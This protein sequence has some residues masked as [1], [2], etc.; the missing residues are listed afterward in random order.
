MVIQGTAEDGSGLEGTVNIFT[1]LEE[2]ELGVGLL[3]GQRGSRA[4]AGGVGDVA[5]GVH[6]AAPAGQ[7]RLVAEHLLVRGAAR[8]LAIHA[9]HHD[10]EGTRT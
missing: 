10:A 2:G 9:V 7:P 4:A 1:Y 5:A 6:V 8:H 3:L